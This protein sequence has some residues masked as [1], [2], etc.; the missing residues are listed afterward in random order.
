[1]SL[2]SAISSM[3]S[4]TSSRGC[5][6]ARANKT[7]SERAIKRTAAETSNRVRTRLRSSA[8]WPEKGTR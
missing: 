4:V 8:I 7:P 5:R 6:A 3:S 2:V 1:M